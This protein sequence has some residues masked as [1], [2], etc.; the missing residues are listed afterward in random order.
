MSAATG[1]ARLHSK[2]HYRLQRY[3]VEG[4]CMMLG[5]AIVIWSLTPIYNMWLIAL[6]AHGDIFSGELWPSAPTL[7][8]FRVV[9]YEDF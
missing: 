4:A 8:A 6:S 7:E 5:V 9:I 2:W 1:R 3:A